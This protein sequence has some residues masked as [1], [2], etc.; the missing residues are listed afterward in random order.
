MLARCETQF[1]HIVFAWR[2]LGN[3]TCEVVMIHPTDAAVKSQNWRRTSTHAATA[4]FDV[5]HKEVRNVALVCLHENLCCCESGCSQL[6][7][8]AKALEAALREQI[9]HDDLMELLLSNHWPNILDEVRTSP[10]T[11]T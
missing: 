9:L 10:K 7:R 2:S 11:G 6:Y 1:L 5:E 4:G 8:F 3:F